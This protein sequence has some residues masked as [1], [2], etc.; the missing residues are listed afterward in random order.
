MSIAMPVHPAI[1]AHQQAMAAA[2]AQRQQ[3]QAAHHAAQVAQH[4]ANVAARTSARAQMI[5]DRQAAA[6]AKKEAAA[7]AKAAKKATADQARANRIAAGIEAPTPAA[8]FDSGTAAA[9]ATQANAGDLIGAQQGDSSSAVP[10]SPATSS[11]T[12]QGSKTSSGFLASLSTTEKIGLVVGGVVVIG[13]FLVIHRAMAPV[14]H[15]N[16]IVKASKNLAAAV[17]G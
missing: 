2:K 6:A 5:G 12:G 9:D 13:G 15:V 7:A 1:T 17:K 16:R 3:T 11:G 10:A 4:T 8:A 14:R